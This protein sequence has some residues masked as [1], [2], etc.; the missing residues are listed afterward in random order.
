MSSSIVPS[1][2]DPTESEAYISSF[3]SSNPDLDEKLG[4]VKV[5]MTD[6]Y[7]DEEWAQQIAETQRRV[8]HEV[9][10]RGKVEGGGGGGGGWKY[11][12]PET[13]SVK[14]A[15]T[16]DHTLLKLDAKKE[17]IDALCSEAR[18][19]GFKVSFFFLFL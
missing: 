19:E 18:T 5:D 1:K 10:A 3:L 17:G 14:F 12:I 4:D 13:G 11:P 6:R 9:Q 15:K 2:H 16:I 7:T 8:L